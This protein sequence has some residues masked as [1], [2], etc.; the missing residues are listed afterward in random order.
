MSEI[1]EAARMYEAV[2]GRKA[3]GVT[4]VAVGLVWAIE[5]QPTLL[6]RVRVAEQAL[7]LATTEKPHA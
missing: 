4:A 2:T 5:K 6:D 1:S 3:E 7:R